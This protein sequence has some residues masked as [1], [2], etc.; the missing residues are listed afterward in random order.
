[1]SSFDEHALDDGVRPTDGLSAAE[2]LNFLLTNRIPRHA[3][4]RFMGWYSRIESPA[5]A[6]VSIGLWQW[7][8]D[9]LRLEE[10][11]ERRF[12]SLHA[13]FTRRLRQGARPL[14]PRPEIVISPCDAVI[15]AHG[16]LRG[17]VALQA[18][19]FPY[20]ID[21]LLGDPATARSVSAGH[22]VTLRLKSSMYHRLHAPAD[23]R[24]DSLRYISGDTWNVNPAALKIV[25]RLY[26]KNERVVLPFRLDNHHD[27]HGPTLYLVAVAAVLVASVRIHGLDIPLNLAYRGPN[28]L[29]LGKRY[30]RGDELG[31]FEHGSTVVVLA[32][33]GLLPLAGLNTGSVI[34]MG[35]PLLERVRC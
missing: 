5:L 17:L 35:Q 33:P 16:P 29:T 10:A 9:D 28:R 21:D 8:V 2:R 4:T 15:G 6:R 18:K 19:G 32:P 14:D 34:R 25:Q 23:G 27:D 30:R 11:A 3:L 13:C 12:D 20:R 26:C 7:F 22:F 31:Y 1:M 24:I